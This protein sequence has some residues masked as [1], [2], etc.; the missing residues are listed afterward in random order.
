MRS[1]N[2]TPAILAARCLSSCAGA[3]YRSV[4]DGAGGALLGAIGGNLLLGAGVGALAG[5]AGTAGF[6]E[7]Q[8]ETREERIVRNCMRTRGYSVLG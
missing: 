1:L 4:V 7:S 5:L 8:T 3:D 6:E 2:P